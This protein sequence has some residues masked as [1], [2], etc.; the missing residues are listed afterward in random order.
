MKDSAFS[1]QDP[2]QSP[3][4]SLWQVTTLWQRALKPVLEKA[5]LSHA[6]FV[7]MAVLCWLM[8]HEQNTNQVDIARMSKL[9]KM[10]I[11]KGLRKLEQ[12]K[13]IKRTEDPNDTRAKQVKLTAKGKKEVID[14]I[15]QIE[16]TDG[17]FFSRLNAKEI[18]TL[19]S[20]L[21]KLTQ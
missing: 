7:I 4:F 5:G 9:D 14:A 1:V 13:L 8:E 16:E 18:S 11:S 17:I 10:T 15:A 6:Q 12:E 21:G 19:N 3:G 2:A 20:L